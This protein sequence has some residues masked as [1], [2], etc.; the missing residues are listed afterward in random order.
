MT[1]NL[2][3]PEIMEKLKPEFIA[4][5]VLCLCSEANTTS[6]M[7]FNCA[8]GWYSRTEIL[9]SQGITLE[10]DNRDI[11]PEDIMARWDEVTGLDEIK[12]LSSVIESFSYLSGLL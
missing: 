1:E 8:G 2:M 5:L 7:I 12:P 6:K 10:D 4:P 11:L 3:P 9:C